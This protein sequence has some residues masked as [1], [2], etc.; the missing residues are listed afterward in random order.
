MPKPKPEQLYL[1]G[2]A[3]PRD[4]DIESKLEAWLDA[5]DAKLAASEDTKLCH[6]VLLATLQERGV[7]AY[8]YRDRAT[9]E[10][11]VIKIKAGEPK[12]CTAKAPRAERVDREKDMAGAGSAADRAKD[13]RSDAHRKLDDA[14]GRVFDGGGL[15]RQYPAPAPREPA[16]SASA[17]VDTVTGKVTVAHNGKTVEVKPPVDD[18]PFSSER[19]RKRAAKREL[20][21][22]RVELAGAEQAHADRINAASDP[23]ASTRA[24]MTPAQIA[25]AESEAA[26]EARRNGKAQS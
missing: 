21:Q 10:K 11:R 5:T 9:G 17:S 13:S 20:E 8:P 16:A 1:D 2:T 7:K 14:L 18:E 6:L 25:V 26:R 19:E 15:P 22:E 23:F 4:E 24:A 12:V 3:P